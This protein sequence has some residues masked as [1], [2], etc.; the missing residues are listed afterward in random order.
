VPVLGYGLAGQVDV[1]FP[2]YLAVPRGRGLK[3][4]EERVQHVK[5]FTDLGPHG[6]VQRDGLDDDVLVAVEGHAGP[7]FLPELGQAVLG[8]KE[9][10]L[11][12][13]RS[14]LMIPVALG[15]AKRPMP[16]PL[17]R[18]RTAKTGKAKLAWQEHEEGRTTRRRRP[19]LRW[20]R[21]GCRGGRRATPTPARP[22]GTRR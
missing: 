12:R 19:C 13:S 4:G 11:M 2:G 8:V 10:V 22:R 7:H 21:A 1:Q 6:V 14:K 20:R 16:T 9:W 5:L 3:L 15:A 18:S 17:R